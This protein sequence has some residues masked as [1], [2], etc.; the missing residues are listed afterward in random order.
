MAQSALATAERSLFL[1]VQHLVDDY[2]VQVNEVGVAPRRLDAGAYAT[3][4]QVKLAGE[5]PALDKPSRGWSRQQRLAAHPLGTGAHLSLPFTHVVLEPEA[6]T[7]PSA[8]PQLPRFEAGD[9]LRSDPIG[10]S[11][12]VAWSMGFGSNGHLACPTPAA[13]GRGAN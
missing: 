2:Q 8:T 4:A 11:A 1:A 6:A 9:R 12:N 7:D 5:L 3:T 10:T 13:G